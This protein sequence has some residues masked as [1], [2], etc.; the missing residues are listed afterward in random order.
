MLNMTNQPLLFLRRVLRRTGLNRVIYKLMHRGGYEKALN[1]KLEACIRPGDCVWDVGANIGLYTLRF[2]ELVGERGRIFAFEPSQVNFRRLQDAVGVAANITVFEFGLSD[3]SR[4]ETF[5]QG[6]DSLGTTSRVRPGQLH[7][8]PRV[9]LRS[10]DDLVSEAIAFSPQVI[11]IDVE[12]HE[13]EVLKGLTRQLANPSLKHVFIEV[14][15][16]IL[17]ADNRSYVPKEL[18][19]LLCDCGLE[20]KWVGASHLHA[21]RPAEYRDR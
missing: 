16:G 7:D 1:D 11:K 9:E 13:L 18:V 4:Y 17:S 12:G 20:T 10:G 3:R 14:H 19:S 8:G 6:G 5:D 21:Y 15:F 2:A